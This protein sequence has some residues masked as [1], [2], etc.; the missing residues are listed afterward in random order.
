M[1]E[2]R[3]SWLAG[4]LP[5]GCMELKEPKTTIQGGETSEMPFQD[6]GEPLLQTAAAPIDAVAQ[7]PMGAEP[8]ASPSHQS[9][10]N[11]RNVTL[12]RC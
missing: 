12:D 5:E 7:A 10:I 1:V 9:L 6:G 4:C 3:G 11:A 8:K 2:G